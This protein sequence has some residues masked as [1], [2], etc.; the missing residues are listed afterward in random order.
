[1]RVSQIAIVL[2]VTLTSIVSAEAPSHLHRTQAVLRRM[3]AHGEISPLLEQARRAIDAAEVAARAGRVEVAERA[4]G[5]ADAAL[6]LL[7]TRRARDR[8]R[9]ASANARRRADA[10]EVRVVEARGAL[11]ATRAQRAART[12]ASLDAGV[13][14]G[15]ADASL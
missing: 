8:A 10:A 2:I 1:M 7:R 14:D 5:I 6:A 12:S 15:G 9:A 4:L 13:A 3:S 11:A